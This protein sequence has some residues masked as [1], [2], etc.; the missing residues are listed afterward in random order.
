MGVVKQ[1][2]GGDATGQ[3]LLRQPGVD[4]AEVV[5]GPAAEVAV[6]ML[7]GRREFGDGVGGRSGLRHGRP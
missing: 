4:G 5:E 3:G 6:E 1:R 7:C 2:S